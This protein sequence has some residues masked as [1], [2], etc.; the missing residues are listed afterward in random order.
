MMSVFEQPED[1]A[2]G[3]WGYYVLPKREDKRIR[4]VDVRHDFKIHYI[5]FHIHEHGQRIR[6]R[7]LTTGKKICDMSPRYDAKGKITEVHQV[8]LPEGILV[9]KGDVLEI[10][11]EYDNPTERPIE[12]MGA[13]ILFGRCRVGAPDCSAFSQRPAANAD[14]DRDLYYSLLGPG[15]GNHTHH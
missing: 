10:L 15:K 13:A 9:E 3:H 4:L 12:T 11:V 8:G 14:F 6:L 1:V 2:P 7:N 5:T